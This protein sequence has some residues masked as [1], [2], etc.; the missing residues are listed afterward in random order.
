MYV[1]MNKSGRKRVEGYLKPMEK[2]A[3]DRNL[4]HY[5]SYILGGLR[6]FFPLIMSF[7]GVVYIQKNGF[8]FSGTP[9]YKVC[10]CEIGR[11]HV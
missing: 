3:V 2:G 5:G 11:A 6:F 1:K 4:L 8:F 10:S 9:G 7:L